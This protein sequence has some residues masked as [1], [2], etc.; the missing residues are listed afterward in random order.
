MLI[1]DGQ[2][3]DMKDLELMSNQGSECVV[4]KYK[5]TAI[6]LFRKN[7]QFSN[8][9]MDDINYVK[10][11]PT[12][13]TLFPTNAILDKDGKV[14][15]YQMTLI[16]KE[17]DIQKEPMH[18]ILKEL[19]IFQYDLMILERFNIGLLDINPSNSIYNGKLYLID[20][21]NY[22][23]NKTGT[24]KRQMDPLNEC[25]DDKKLLT[26]WNENKIN[27]LFDMLLFSQNPKIDPY[28]F[29]LIVQFFIREKEKKGINYNYEVFKKYFDPD[30]S[31]E[32]S[33]NKFMK[34]H[35][36]VDPLERKWYLSEYRKTNKNRTL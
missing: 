29:R 8:L 7:Y 9:T 31:V 26:T 22:L 1:I 27:Q 18:K 14:V 15:G 34:E 4:Y 6:K 24:I 35:I 11:I 13:R 36:K 10:N 32:D 23:I 16:K 2:H 20:P 19:L 30:L 17:K 3:I 21:G 28:Q 5:N 33:I 25:N 12:R